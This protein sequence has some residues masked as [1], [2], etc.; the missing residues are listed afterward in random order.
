MKRLFMTA[1]VS[2]LLYTTASHAGTTGKIVGQVSD[3]DTK[4][5]LAGAQVR[6]DG[7]RIGTL[8]DRSGRYFLLNVPPGTYSITASLIGHQD[9][10]KD[11]AEVIVDGTT[12]I[13]FRLGTRVLEMPAMTITAERPLLRRDITSS[14]KV[15][16]NKKI[17][18]LPVNRLDE[19]L[20]Y[21]PGFVT[22]ANNNLH[23]RGGR[24]GELAYFIDGLPV[25]NSL[26]GGIN[27]LLNDD[28]I[29]QLVILTGTFNAEYGNALSGVIN[30][31]TKE[32]GE[33]FHGQVEYKSV[34]INNSPYR[35]KDWAGEGIDSQRDPQTG[36]SLY[37]APDVFDRKVR[38]PLPGIISASFSGPVVGLDDVS[39]YVSTRSNKED[40][41]LPFGYH[42]EE[43]LNWKVNYE[44][45]KGGKI[46]LLG[47]NSRNEYQDYSHA[48][49]YLPDNRVTNL[50]SSDRI[51]LIWSENIGRSY[52]LSA[53]GSRDRQF[54]DISV[55]DK[56]PQ[57]YTRGETDPSLNFYVQGD[58]NIFQRSRITTTLGKV[59]LIHQQG[60]RHEIKAGGE[61]RYHEIS[62]RQFQDPWFNLEDRY[63]Q[64]PIEGS[65]YLQDKIE[66]EFFV[67]NAGLR[68]DFVDPRATMWSDLENPESPM[69]KVPI[70][71]QF[72][73][74]ISMSHP[75]T[76]K[77][78]IYFSYGHFFQ[79]PE[80]DLFFS[81]T[82]NLNPDNL[83]D[84]SFGNVGN[85][86]IKP[87]KTVAYE[88]GVKQEVTDD[89]G[90]SV[91]AFFKDI[92]NLIGTEEVRVTT[93][94]SSYHY[95]YFTNI[96]YANVKGI[97]LSLDRRY[98]NHLAWDLNY[99]Y[100]I[101]KGNRSFPLEGYYNVY[102]EQQEEN[103]DFF[104]DF[105]RRH[106]ISGDVTLNSG[107]WE[108]P[109]FLGFHPFAHS[110]ISTVV[111]YTSGLPY[112]PSS[113]VPGLILEKNSARLPWN[114]TV[115]LNIHKDIRTGGLRQ[116]LFLEVSNIFNRRNVLYVNPLTGELWQTT[117]GEG[118]SAEGRDSAFDP[119]DV[120]APR[121]IRFGFRT[122]F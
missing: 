16:S 8:T 73:P 112:T 119:S 44:A 46:T 91:T 122:A 71:T 53:M 96:D 43:D 7:T 56:L 24:T 85:R 19:I 98:N 76:D 66:Y 90:L 32:G 116:T 64:H 12:R 104:L 121:I 118:A 82:R 10:T 14:I 74:R 67:L 63:S 109:E 3:L 27:S 5:P 107:S 93:E 4:E 20:K 106:S 37:A 47:Q 33:D 68:F 23:I 18:N 86:D 61:I 70:K 108:G 55:G 97:E 58:D 100:S 49:K 65:A 45:G 22:D 103:Q 120:G 34:M 89:L 2:I 79:N 111:Q 60:E 57:E 113:G 40:S 99:T 39:F 69:V 80:Y 17:E 77:S 95:T 102:Y 13:D 115:D 114:G 84:L 94:N 26:F 6:I 59:D 30:V 110:G 29:D 1:A 35:K 101:A 25:E 28:S 38:L 72:S 88:V 81:N 36:E 15:V 42:L 11:S 21:Q 48:W 117:G 75:I 31:V 87:Q 83:D 54:Y 105:D 9:V 62:F 52:Y 78:L 51:G 50:K 41:Y 92:S